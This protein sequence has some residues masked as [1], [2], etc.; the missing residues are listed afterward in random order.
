MSLNKHASVPKEHTN[1]PQGIHEC[2]LRYMH[3]NVSQGIWSVPQGPCMQV[4]L[5]GHVNV[6]QEKS[7]YP[8]RGGIKCRG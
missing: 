7:D 2:P 3:V 5:K 1:V 6:F 8:P 4:S